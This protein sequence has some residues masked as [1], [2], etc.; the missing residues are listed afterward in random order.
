MSELPFL[1]PTKPPHPS[2][3]PR[4]T[5]I[6]TSGK[7]SQQHNH[8]LTTPSPHSLQ[9]SDRDKLQSAA[10]TVST[11]TTVG[12]LVG[13]GL[14]LF[15][16]YRVRSNRLAMFQAFKTAEKPVE[17]RFANGRTGT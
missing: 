7:S 9:D 3:R 16:A 5:I 1:L 13:L 10:N 6:Q 4:S 14:G 2:L 8:N 11:H 17:V 15:L 12:S